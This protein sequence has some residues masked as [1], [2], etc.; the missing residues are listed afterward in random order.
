[1]EFVVALRFGALRGLGLR[2]ALLGLRIDTVDGQNPRV[3]LKVEGS[4]RVPLRGSFK[5]SIGF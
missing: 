3:P 1:M 4:I 5:G 2:L